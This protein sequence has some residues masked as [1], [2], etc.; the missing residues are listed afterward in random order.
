MTRQ[1]WSVVLLAPA[2]IAGEVVAQQPARSRPAIPAPEG[3][4]PAPALTLDAVVR[5]AARES[6]SVLTAEEAVAQARGA[7][8]EAGEAFDGRLTTTL[9]SERENT[10]V[11]PTLDAPT[12]GHYVTDRVVYSLGYERQLRSGI[13]LTP[14]L[15][16]TRAAVTSVPGL[17]TGTASAGLDVTIPLLNNR[18][19][20]VARAAERSAELAYGGSVEDFRQSTAESVYD[21]VVAY[22]GYLAAVRRLAVDRTAEQRA[23][24][25]VSETRELVRADERPAAD[26]QQ[27]LANAAARGAARLAAE[28]AVV[29]AREALG[30]AMGAT[31]SA[32]LALPLPA[33]DFPAMNGAP[34]ATGTD[35]AGDPAAL[36]RLT[37][38]ALERRGDVRGAGRRRS[39]ALAEL[40]GALDARKPRLDLVVGTGYV[41]LA[42][43][44]G[45][46]GLVLPIHQ[47]VPGLNT[48]VQ[49]S[50]QLP[51]LNAGAR[52]RAARLQAVAEQRAIAERDLAR[53]VV[54]GV[55][56]AAQALRTGRLARAESERAVALSQQAVE[57]ERS[58]F[59]LGTA[60][61]FD[62]INAES[63]LIS[64][65]LAEVDARRV[66]AEAVVGLRFAT[67]TLVA[68]AARPKGQVGELTASPAAV[69][70][71][72]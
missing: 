52:G 22:W 64:A 54:T 56:V 42:Q 53:R 4:A 44:N 72:P 66:H 70:T 51:T 24:Q 6:P 8:V 50:S 10:L 69:T 55:A 25:L 1:L 21:A 32:V 40:D 30:L 62:I 2:L 41:G 61:L 33:T 27:L 48:V 15:E 5:A 34:G 16:T 29:A 36:R 35:Y 39:A 57:S 67:G 31:G 3:G 68:P 47:N 17:P 19:G 9:E 7:R 58:R 14:R 63:S 43:A 49:L 13:V 60:T 11:P 71:P 46:R 23:G 20:R 18:G 65:Q 59:Q 45:M 12:V 37:E 28:Q 26:T 38:A